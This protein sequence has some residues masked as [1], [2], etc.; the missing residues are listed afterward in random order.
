MDNYQLFQRY[1]DVCN[2]ALDMNKD[3]FPFKQILLPVQLSQSSK[4]IEVSIID[5][6]PKDSYT[7]TVN[8]HHLVGNIHGQCAN[9]KCDGKWRIHKSYLEDVIR[10]PDEYIQN[11]AKIDWEW[12][13]ES[14]H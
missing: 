12:L 9:C 10:H 3:K 2:R 1:L 14:S 4:T 5:D 7:L 13:I 6:L 11:P 8:G